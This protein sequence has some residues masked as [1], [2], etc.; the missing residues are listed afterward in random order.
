MEYKG[1][2]PDQIVA[3]GVIRCPPLGAGSNLL[4]GAVVFRERTN[5]RPYQYQQVKLAQSEGVL[6]P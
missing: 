1:K 4:A 3:V 5:E 2:E 6:Y